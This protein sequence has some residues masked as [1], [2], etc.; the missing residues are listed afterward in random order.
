MRETVFLLIA[1]AIVGAF[2]AG[3]SY[4]E[5]DIVRSCNNFASFVADDARYA[6]NLSHKI[7]R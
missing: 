2:F 1:A 4:K 3:M 6:C 5:E 7:Q